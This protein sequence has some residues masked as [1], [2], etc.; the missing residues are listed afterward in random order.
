MKRALPD[1]IQ[2]LYPLTPT[3]QGMLF[4]SIAEP[5]HGVYIIQVSF[6]LRGKLDQ[7]ILSEAWQELIQRHDVLRTAFV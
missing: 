4:H 7:K 6:T 2:D 3:Q 1:H 5:N